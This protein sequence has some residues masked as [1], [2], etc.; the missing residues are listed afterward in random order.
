[1]IVRYLVLAV[2]IA[3]VAGEETL[4]QFGGLN[5]KIGKIGRAADKMRDIEMTE[6]EEIKLGEDVSL[7]VRQKYGVV[8]DPAV[9]KYVALVGRVL[10]EKSGRPNFPFQFIILDTDGVN[11]FAAPGGFVHITRGALALIQ[12]EAE[13]AGVLGHE[14]AH[15]TERHAIRAIQSGKA[16]QMAASETSVTSSPVLF[17]RLADALYNVVYQGYS[18]RDELDADTVGVAVSASAGYAPVGL[19]KFLF[20]LKQR[21]SS[22]DTKQG[23]FGSHPETDQRLEKIAALIERQKLESKAELE[24]R[25]H[26]QIQYKLTELAEITDV[27]EGTQGVAGGGKKEEKK[28]EE[29]K[30]KSRFGLGNI[31][32]L[33]GGNKE[34]TQSAS[35]GGSGGSRAVDKERV[36]KGG[37]N[38]AVVAVAIT[39]KELEQFKKEGK[40]G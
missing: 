40:L 35:T 28:E 12:H 39:A 32:S 7:R 9:H 31:K 24:D 5:D 23:L 14:I 27:A 38:P 13:L 4:A 15:V 17:R 18:P 25:Y 1:M 36:A 33:G 22:S 10:V 30:K 6:A 8:Q 37:D 11:A 34:T 2:L 19:G 16:V 26:K 29:P 20:D 21:N 3:G